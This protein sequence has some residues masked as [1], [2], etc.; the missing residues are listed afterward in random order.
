MKIGPSNIFPSIAREAVKTATTSNSGDPK[1][2][3][4]GL[5]RVQARLQRAPATDRNAGH[6]TALDRISRN[7]A[8]Y[9]ETQAIIPA[10]MNTPPTVDSMLTMPAEAPAMLPPTSA[11]EPEVP[12]TQA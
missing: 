5:E 6:A 12:A 2:V 1:P 4:P 9:A 7:I 10:P 3:P 11:T 8:R